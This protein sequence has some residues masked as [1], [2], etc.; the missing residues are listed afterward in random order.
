MGNNHKPFIDSEMLSAYLDDALSDSERKAVEAYLA[1]SG[2][3]RRELA[4]LQRCRE[5]FES[6]KAPDPA[7]FFVQRVAIRLVHEAHQDRRR[8][9]WHRRLVQRLAP[10]AMVLFAA[11]ALVFLN[12]HQQKQVE[13]VTLEVYLRGFLDRDVREVTR[14]VESEL[15][16]DDVLN[17]VLS[18]NAR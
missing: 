13:H 16:R 18:G 10:A 3:A 6:W 1:A 7:P 14:L 8:N 4:E 5:W 11:G 9:P 15:S 2:A 17:I 12:H